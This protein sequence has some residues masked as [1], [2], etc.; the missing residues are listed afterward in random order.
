VTN[1]AFLFF[2]LYGGIFIL[3]NCYLRTDLPFAYRI[4][5]SCLAFCL[6]FSGG[7]GVNLF[8]WGLFHRERMFDYLYSQYWIFPP[9]AGLLIRSLSICADILTFR[10][11][12]HMAQQRLGARMLAIR[13]FPFIAFM[14]ILSAFLEISSH[15]THFHHPMLHNLV[16]V[17]CMG[18]E[19]GFYFW[20]NRFFRAKQTERLMNVVM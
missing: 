4:Q 19:F 2:M 3:N 8:V 1:S 15:I 20:W 17:I 10:I 6:I 9:F 11:G 5:N 13:F 16:L 7:Q 12:F 18:L 14:D